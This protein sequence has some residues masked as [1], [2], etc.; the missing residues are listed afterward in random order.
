MA[1]GGMGD[2]LTGVCAALL[3][4]GL[5]T[6]TAGLLGAWLCGRSAE[7]LLSSGQRSEESLLASDVADGLGTAFEALR[8]PSW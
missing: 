4:R 5:S 3:A 6:H 7:G 8:Q 2:V 1:S